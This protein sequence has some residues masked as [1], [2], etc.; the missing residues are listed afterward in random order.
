MP[1]SMIRS[2]L[3]SAALLFGVCGS[4]SAQ[5]EG[6]RTRAQ[7]VPVTV[8]LVDRLPQ[9]GSP[10]LVQRRPDLRPN[11]VILLPSDATAAALSDAV[12]TL[13]TARQVSGDSPTARVTMRMRPHRQGARVAAREFPWVHRVLADLRHSGRRDVAGVGKVRAVEI[14]LPR[15]ARRSQRARP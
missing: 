15:Q 12:R 4:L 14:W 3:L 7:R 11:D 5:L 1:M 2:E 6:S 9:S 10:F 13:L 8:V